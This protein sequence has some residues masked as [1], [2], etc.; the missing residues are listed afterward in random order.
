M[1]FSEELLVRK[2]ARRRQLLC[3]KSDPFAEPSS[4]SP[5]TELDS[6]D[7]I[8]LR[9]HIEPLDK[10]TKIVWHGYQQEV[11]EDRLCAAM[12]GSPDRN[13]TYGIKRI[14]V[15]DTPLL[16]L[17]HIFPGYIT[18]EYIEITGAQLAILP[19]SFPAATK[20]V[21]ECGAKNSTMK[22]PRVLYA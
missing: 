20:H 12:Q 10:H 15:R 11:F 17:P 4:N 3:S 22:C 13:A 8:E 5:R 18:L 6:E 1:A 9:Q 7:E 2:L 16:F 14:V 19:L 21:K